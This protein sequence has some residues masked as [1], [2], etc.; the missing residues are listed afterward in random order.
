LSP[1]VR[2]GRPSGV[3]QEKIQSCIS[4]G[5]KT[6]HC[7]RLLVQGQGSQYFQVYGPDSDSPNRVPVNSEAAWARVGEQM[8]KAWENVEKR[9]QNT[10]QDGE[11]DKV[12]P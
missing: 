12:N 1:A 5:C 8:A 4:K 6:V 3:E 7:Q 10:I 11:R 2:E 9:A